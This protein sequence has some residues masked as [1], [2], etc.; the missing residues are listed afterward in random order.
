MPETPKR[1]YVEVTTRCNL[2]CKMCVKFTKGSCIAECNLSPQLFNALL[3]SLPQAE[4]LILNGI[5]EP[6]IHPQLISFVTKARAEM[7]NKE[8]CFQSNGLLLNAQIADELI[9]AGLSSICLSVDLMEKEDGEHSFVAINRAVSILAKAR[10]QF[11][12]DFK[13]GL[14]T[15]ISTA[16]Y[17]AIPE[18]VRWACNNPIDHILA[19]H[20]IRYDKSSEASDLFNPNSKG[21]I[22][23]FEK[24]KS[25]AESQGVDIDIAQKSDLLSSGTALPLN[26]AKILS[27][28]RAEAQDK[29]IRLNIPNLIERDKACKDVAKYFLKAQA[30]ADAHGLA[31]DLPPLQALDERRCR[32]IE[33]NAICIT[34]EGEVTPCHYLWHTYACQVHGE[35]VNV[36]KRSFGHLKNT[37]LEDVWNQHEYQQF[38]KEAG[39]YQ[40]THC[41]NCTQGPCPELVSADTDLGHDCYGSTVPCGHCQWNLGGVRCL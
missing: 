30:I 15:V 7:G 18:L 32:F 17:T 16:N 10:S 3:P 24:Y 35:E 34:A 31:L 26:A 5:G 33:E 38:R 19:S 1:I 40:Y 14:E 4:C 12:P 21:S 36:Q 11:N 39:E 2:R 28:L 20:L 41:W 6:L 8:I 27:D 25:Q 29:D 22:E 9:Q 13:I 37:S 23:L